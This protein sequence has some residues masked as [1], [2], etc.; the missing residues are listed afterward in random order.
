MDRSETEPIAKDLISKAK[1]LMKDVNTTVYDDFWAY[2]AFDRAWRRK[3]EYCSG[4]KKELVDQIYDL[5]GNLDYNSTIYL[6]AHITS[7]E[8]AAELQMKAKDGWQNPAALDKKACIFLRNVRSK[9]EHEN[10]ETNTRL[11]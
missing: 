6:F 4:K 9:V 5:I 1:E 10:S 7:A 3:P 11:M 8:I 2:A